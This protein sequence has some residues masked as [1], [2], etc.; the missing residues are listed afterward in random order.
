MTVDA[1][2]LRALES[3]GVRVHCPAATVIEGVEPDQ[4][5]EG[6]E[7]FPSVTIRGAGSHFGAG[8]VLGRA[9]G[10]Y[11]EDVQCGDGCDL[12]GGYYKSC[13]L[14]DGVIIRGHA[15]LRGGTLLE[16][17]CEAAHH[18]GYKMT[19][20]LPWVVAGS[21]VNFCDALVAGGTSRRDHSEIGSSLALYNFT[22]WGDKYASMFGDVP[23]G[24]FL[25]ERPVFIGG[26]TKIVSP[27]KV[28]F[29]TVLPAGCAVRRDVA[30]GLIYGEA[31]D[32]FSMP[33]N[34]NT[35]GMLS[36]K[37]RTTIE[38]IGN[39]VALRVWYDYVRSPSASAPG[40]TTLYAAA[41]AQIDAGIA[42][43]IKR[44]QKIVDRLAESKQ[45]HLSATDDALTPAQRRR[46]IDD[47]DLI[48]SRWAA[49]GAA[50]HRVAG[51][52][53]LDASDAAVFAEC[54]DAVR[55]AQAEGAVTFAECVK[56]G[57]DDR[58]AARGSE[59][60][61][62]IVDRLVSSSGL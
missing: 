34:P 43:R 17:G 62:G 13:T 20:M 32:G 2:L 18:V 53:R 29:G 50:L 55:R 61:A 46:R 31:V 24:V 8:S 14:L 52:L 25:R 54:V 37:F 28:G 26:Q 39:L 9:G 35:L 4:F 59:T 47:H 40:H 58:L 23:R 22:P 56:R 21:L 33:F 45:Q 1:G 49:A 7:I 51:E 38:Y 5:G 10:G 41:R 3:R 48:L 60:L 36:H 15:E 6:V 19:V 16:E 27:V 44:L 11:F 42:E 30:D 12:F 57:V